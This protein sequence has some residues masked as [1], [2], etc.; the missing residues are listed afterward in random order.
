M[1]MSIDFLGGLQIHHPNA[2]TKTGVPSVLTRHVSVTIS[3]S[4]CFYCFLQ[5]S[6]VCTVD[7][8]VVDL[9]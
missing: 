9:R 3:Y 8:R 7:L 4:S 6:D 5:T 2:S 1:G